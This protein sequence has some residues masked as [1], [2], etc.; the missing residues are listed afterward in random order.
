MTP[1]P[2]IPLTL[3]TGPLGS[4]KTRLINIAIAEPT[5]AGALVLANE[6]GAT[7][8]SRPA[9]VLQDMPALDR[10]ACLCCSG[11]GR[12]AALLE[13]LL[14]GLDNKRL[15]AFDRLIV[16]TAGDADPTPMLAELIGHPYLGRRYRIHAVVTVIPGTA[17]PDATALYRQLAV[18]DVVVTPR[19]GDPN[20]LTDM[21]ERISGQPAVISWPA[22]P[23]DAAV[24]LA[25]HRFALDR[26]PESLRRRL[27]AASL[28]GPLR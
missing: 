13:T 17:P 6:S 28:R 19:D 20:W 8:L 11:Q 16:E 1:P 23:S 25:A 7:A 21:R 4:G 14:R 26:K 18:A 12:F 27:Y 22:Q 3:V 15:P 9:P 24:L 5:L 10:Q 2:P